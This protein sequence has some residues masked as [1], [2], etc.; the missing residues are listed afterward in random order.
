M[1]ESTLVLKIE[2]MTCGGCEASLV[3]VLSQLEG[4][5][6]VQASHQRREAVLRVD[7][8]RTPS[9]EVLSAAVERAGFERVG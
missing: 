2:G 6:G 7:A 8:D 1:A 4:V 5:R 3:R 9:D